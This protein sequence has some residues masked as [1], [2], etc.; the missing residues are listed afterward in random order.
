V[1]LAVL[2]VSAG[3]PVGV[4][5]LTELIWD[6]DQPE[7][8]RARLQTLVARVRG[9]V[10]GVVVTAGEGYLLDV[11]PD[12][13]DLW[14][15]RRLVR[16]A[17]EASSPA[18]A[19]GLLDQA[20]G[21]WRGEPMADLRSAALDRA[22]RPALTDE[23]LSAVQQRADLGL[24]AGRYDQITAELRGLTGQ[25]PLREP[26]WGQLLRALAG[27]GRPAEAIREYHRAREILAAELGVDPSPDLQGL[28]RQLLQADRHAVAAGE[29]PGAPRPQPQIPRQQGE[30][31]DPDRPAGH[32]RETAARRVPHR[33]PADTRVFTGRQPELGRLLALAGA[34]SGSD[35]PGT[36][37][38]S[39]IDG[40]AGIG[41]TALAVHAAHRLAGR[42]GDG[43]LFIDLHGYTQ[44]YPPRTAS[45]ALETF[46][47]AL[48]VPP[49]QIPEDAEERAALY[50][51]RLAGTR[52]LIVLDNAADEAQVR[53][54][55]PG[56][57]GCLI[58]V[59]SRRKLK[60]LD[61]SHALALDVL[62]APDAITLLRAV[63]GPDRVAAD[64]P[65]VAEIA[66]LC[67]HVPLAV[68]IAAALMRSR[69]TWSPQYLADKLRAERAR[70]DALFDGDRDVS[71]LFDLSSQIL[72]DDQRHLYCY[73]GLSPGP[74][75][76]AY[77]AAALLDTDAATAERLMQELVDHNLVLEPRAGRYRLHDLIRAHSRALA[78]KDPAAGEAALER[79]LD[80]YQHTARRAN[81][82]LAR[83][84]R[85]RI[86]GPA[87]AHAPA[88]PDAPGACAWLRAERANL[89]ACLQYAI[90]GAM[91]ARTVALSVGLTS[92]LRTDGPW[93]QAKAAQTAAAA[94]ARRLGDRR[95]Q[96]RALTELGDLCRLTGDYPG[97]DRSLQTALE[98]WREA[99][100]K[101][102]QARALT[103]LGTVRRVSG[104]YQA[105]DR[106]LQTALELWREAGDKPGQA[107]ALTE[108]GTVQYTSGDYQAAGRRLRAAL[109]L[110]RKAGDTPGQ[111]RA[112]T[113]LSE[114]Q[115]LT[116]AYEDAIRNS[117]AA[118]AISDELGDRLGHANALSR[119]GRMRRMTG[120]Y[121][122]AAWHQRAALDLYR[123][124]GDRLGEANARMM[125]GEVRSLTG[126]HE[127]AARDL[128]QSIGTFR[129]LGNRGN[130]PCALN[131]YAAAISAAGDLTRAITIYHDAL[132]QAREVQ[133]PD[134]EAAALEGLG[135]NHMR[136]GNLQ[137]GA[138]YLHQ[139]L[140]IYRR[141]G[142]PAAEQITARL[143]DI[144]SL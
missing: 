136:K 102:G 69:P 45:Q 8:A 78:E 83:C 55:I 103:E 100:D 5:R 80:Y 4:T 128:E 135:E 86:A 139:A 101:P 98:L 108:L 1:L 81:D 134:D 59:T 70:L 48:G 93:P 105:A 63:A 66:G 21:L 118:L 129:D 127:G 94:A 62:P 120:D 10:P 91:D 2:A 89:A 90:Q 130:Q 138:T 143:A 82:R 117:E 111:A 68:R 84:A 96:A 24:A 30:A 72:N 124:L 22:V 77:A 34:A 58:L 16:A 113:E 132:R 37:V 88:L 28:Y 14:Q 29:S 42:F 32:K 39:A 6:D 144:R 97:A 25:H 33:L 131:Y 49:Q 121:E 71:A 67:G 47:L 87:H 125:L 112:L 57:T 107:R 75:T 12:A 18:A 20:L 26:L 27:A 11:D 65:A 74:E 54:L 76:D 133:Q 61:D 43:Q 7:H 99:G 95:A 114:M 122:D 123:E 140:E 13:V 104:D 9:Q 110:Y 17:G 56:R 40:M 44:G 23:Y 15:F 35:G 126:D 50:R 36:V 106:S 73:L 115:R 79:L 109:Q 3:H 52:T 41:K 53:P 31:A 19:L 51:E 92:L 119:L 137:D 38:I 85:P 142:V 46:L 116:G 60:S 141:L 64:D